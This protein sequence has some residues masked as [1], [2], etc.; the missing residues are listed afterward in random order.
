MNDESKEFKDVVRRLAVRL[1]GIL[2]VCVYVWSITDPV[3]HEEVNTTHAIIDNVLGT[4][5][6]FLGIG[7][8]LCIAVLCARWANE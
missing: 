1:S 3:L 7:L 5:M 6:T 8:L 4:T 2:V